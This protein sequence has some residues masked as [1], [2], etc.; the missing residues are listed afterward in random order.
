MKRKLIVK[1]VIVLVFFLAL[2]SKI[3][4]QGQDNN[5]EWNGNSIQSIVTATDPDMKTVYLYNV[6]THKFLNAGSHWATVTI[7]YTVGM[8]L[9]IK[10][11]ETTANRYNMTGDTQ[12]TEGSTIAWGRKQ[13]TTPD[14]KKNPINYNNVYVDRGVKN[15][16]NENKINGIID[17]IFEEVRTGSKTYKIYCNNDE[18]LP[19]TENMGG[20][21]YLQLE[22]SAAD[23]LEMKYPHNV[24]SSD[25]TGQWKIV[26]L[27]DLKDAFKVKFASDEKPADATFLIH[28]Q[29]FSR[30]HK[31][32]K[33][34]EKSSG[35]TSALQE[36]NYSFLS[37]KGTYYV[38]IGSAKSDDYQAKYA[39][40]WVATIRNIGDHAHANGTVTQKVHILKKGWYILSCD[41]FYN[42][43]NGSSMKS[44][45]F[46]KVEGYD[47]GSSNVSAEL[48]KFRGDFEYTVEDLT[49]IYGKND[50]AIESPY[51]KAGRIFNEKKY[52]NSLIV[53]VPSDGATLDIGVEVTGSNQGLDL[54]AFDNFQLQYCGDRDI[55]LDESQTDVT[56]INKQVEE[57]VAK[58]LIL[59]RTMKPYQW[60]SI[61]LPV[62]LT[63]AQFKRAFGRS[64]ELS[65][66][67]GQDENLSSRIV[68]TKVNLTN[69]DEVVIFPGKL[70]IMKP[71]RGANVTF[72][73]HT[74]I[75]D[76]YRTIT[77][78]APYYQINGVSLTT[79]T[80]T[81]EFKEQAK[82]ST[83]VDGQLVFSGTYVKHIS[84]NVPKFSY[85]LSANDGKWHYLLKDHSIL[86]FRCWIATGSA[87]LAKQM[88]FS[89][90]GVVDNT[91]GINQT[92]VDDQRP[93]NA[94][95]YTVNGQL[96]RA[97]SS[98]I[99]GLPKG[100]YIVNGK[101]LVVR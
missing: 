101:K 26:T 37:N 81:G 73:D 48:E 82:H 74:K 55:V 78:Q 71:T 97:G 79:E 23:R 99:E 77:V 1:R 83:T 33:K 94:D 34:W 49:K 28:D 44:F 59:K 20:K 45:F 27:K 25:R 50:V 96:V 7:G 52:Q 18:Y 35:L 80:T 91:T 60:N 24:S 89:I 38:G 53:Y 65:V 57:N 6:G 16:Y 69:D 88:T 67:K 36:S 5:H 54:T 12:T 29:N 90:N 15:I 72:G 41:G 61:T 68:F 32:I 64:A 19:G 84:K 47:R 39:S 92:I 43:T 85:V 40:R 3:Y 58:T 22:S 46:A 62:K 93:Q 9:H 30:S 17:W 42:A 95:I 11:S 66:L 2:F 76:N 10:R 4:A 86:G 100:I 14:G 56:Y 63:A 70:Y 51:V 13:D 75:I 87:G 8:G 98:S 21:I 31:E